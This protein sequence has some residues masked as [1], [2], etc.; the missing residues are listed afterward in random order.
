MI[1]RSKLYFTLKYC[2]F[3]ASQVTQNVDPIKYSYSGC[4]IGFDFSSFFSCPGFDCVKN[5]VIF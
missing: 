2:L 1:A 3:G 5:V 4:G